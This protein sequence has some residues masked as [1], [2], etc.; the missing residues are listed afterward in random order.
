[1]N[2][3]MMNTLRLAL[4]VIPSIFVLGG[5]LSHCTGT[6]DCDGSVLLVSEAEC[7][8]YADEF[9]CDSFSFDNGVCDVNGCGTCEDV[10]DDLDPVIDIDDGGF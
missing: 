10:I 8:A 2:K 1:M 7:A 9:F 6:D 4:L 5:V 3:K